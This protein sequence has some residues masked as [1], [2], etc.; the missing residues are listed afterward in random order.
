MRFYQLQSLNLLS[1]LFMFKEFI[2]TNNYSCV[3]YSNYIL[4][5]YLIKPLVI[6]VVA[7]N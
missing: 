1:N 4:I 5:A 3:F 7:N 2:V 6:C